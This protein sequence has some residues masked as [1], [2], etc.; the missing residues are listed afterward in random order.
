MFAAQL[1]Q[2]GLE[3]RGSLERDVIADEEHSQT[4]GWNDRRPRDA[5]V[6]PLEAGRYDGD[7]PRRDRVVTLNIA[8]A[9]RG[10]RDEPVAGLG[11]TPADAPGQRGGDSLR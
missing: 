10:Q 11:G 7:L 2:E 5:D 6:G 1:R 3:K 9:S 4:R 8:R